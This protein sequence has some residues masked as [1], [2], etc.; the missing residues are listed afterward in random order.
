[1]FLSLLGLKLASIWKDQL[2]KF[3]THLEAFKRCINCRGRGPGSI[4]GRDFGYYIYGESE[5]S[6]SYYENTE[7]KS[8]L[9]QATFNIDLSDKSRLSFGGMYYDWESNQVAGWNRLSQDLIDTGSYV[10]GSPFPGLDVDGDGSISHQEYGMRGGIESL[11][12]WG[13]RMLPPSSIR[14]CRTWDWILALLERHI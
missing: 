5:D 1:M 13:L 14:P 9:L 6:D 8:K 12:L 2:A 3:P 7:V 10:T 4:G 11:L